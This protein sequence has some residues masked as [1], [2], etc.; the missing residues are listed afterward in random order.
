MQK[1]N[2]KT[3]AAG[4]LPSSGSRTAGAF[5]QPGKGMPITNTPGSKNALPNP[6]LPGKMSKNQM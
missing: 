6:P 1:L 2:S 4:W 3:N 5:S